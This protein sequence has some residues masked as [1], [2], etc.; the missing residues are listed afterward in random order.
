MD[1]IVYASIPKVDTTKGLL[2][3][4]GN[5]FIKFDM[6]EKHYYLDPLNNTKYDE[7]KGVRDHIIL[8]S[9]YYNKSK[10][11]KDGVYHTGER[12][13]YFNG[14]CGYCKKVGHKKVDCWKLKGKQEKKGN[15]KSKGTNQP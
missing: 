5:K 2:K 14:R 6:N 3:E 11:P 8:L 1:E 15:D 10:G 13:E 9:S 7:V 4:I 12:K